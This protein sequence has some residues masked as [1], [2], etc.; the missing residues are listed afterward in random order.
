MTGGAPTMHP[1]ITSYVYGRRKYVAAN[2]WIMTIQ[3]IPLAFVLTF[4]GV[5]NQ[6][7]I[8]EMAY[9]LMLVMLAVS[10]ITLLT[11]WNIPDANAADREYGNRELK[12]QKNAIGWNMPQA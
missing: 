7:G 4:M 10:F 5:F 3:S 11:M 9:Y 1:C 6:M 12:E 8:L 2:K